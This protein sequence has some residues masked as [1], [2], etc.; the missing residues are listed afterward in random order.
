M[1]YRFWLSFILTLLFLGFIFKFLNLTVFIGYLKNAK[2]YFLIPAIACYAAVY[3]VRARRMNVLLGYGSLSRMYWISI[4]HYFFNKLLPSRTG[5]LSLL[6]FLK[7]YT[8]CRYE[9][10]LVLLL[11]L[12]FMD[13][14]VL[15]TLFLLALFIINFP[16]KN[17]L[18]AYAPLLTAILIFQ[19]S[20]LFCLPW[21]LQ[22]AIKL[23]VRRL[24]K[25]LTSIYEY[26]RQVDYRKFLRP[27]LFDSFLNWF[28]FYGFI[29]FAARAFHITLGYWSILF[30]ATFPVLSM[31]VPV[32]A[33]GNF[34]TFEAGWVLGF[35]LVGVPT[36]SAFAVGFCTNIV[37]T[38]INGILAGLGYLMLNRRHCP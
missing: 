20:V 2:Y 5:E 24:Q 38:I 19:L 18:M 32:S 11:L 10:G 12:R 25:T 3:L 4:L 16:I 31:L 8:D 23:N 17:R 33:I 28:L 7:R 36:D 37:L 27:L 14:F 15:I 13:M 1:K 29:F 26:T 9:K 35:V 6:Y 30:A 34:G 21:I 22:K